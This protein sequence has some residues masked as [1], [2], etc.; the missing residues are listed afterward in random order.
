MMW[1]I[2]ILAA[3]VMLALALIMTFVLGWANEAFHVEVDPRIDKVNEALPGANCGGCGYVGCGEYAEAVVEGEGK[4]ALNLCPVGGDGVVSEMASILGM[5]VEDALPYRPAVHCAATCDDKKGKHEYRGELKC[6][7]A[8]L[9]A[10]VQGCA[11]GCLG[12][13]DC[14][15]SCKFDAIHLLDGKIV[16]DYEK[17]IGCGA[18]EKVCPRKVISMVPFKAEK[19]FV[20]ACSNQD[21][22]KDVKA[23]CKVGCI[24]CKACERLSDGLFAMTGNLPHI[25]YDKYEP[26]KVS[27]IIE[28]VLDKCPSKTIVKIGKPSSKD[29]EAVADEKMPEVVKA[30]FETT[31]DKTEWQG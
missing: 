1:I 24:G 5:K 3:G 29:L 9:V 17:C 4:I 25:E 8:N 18:C 19:M 28:V 10:G 12:I 16:I 6:A 26:T 13:G 22:G 15:E 23:V 31:V 14:V 7:T 20:Q 11:Y 27:T 2:I 30:K 21:F